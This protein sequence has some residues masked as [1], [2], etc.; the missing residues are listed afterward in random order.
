MAVHTHNAHW[1]PP[2]SAAS[3]SR[4]S[5]ARVVAWLAATVDVT[6]TPIAP[7]SCC[8]VLSRPE[9]SPA[10]RSATP[11]SPAIEIGMN[12]NAVPA[13]ATKNGPARSAPE[14]TVHGQPG[15]PT[16]IPARD[17]RH[18]GRHDRRGT[19]PRVTSHCVEPGERHRG[20]RRGQPRESGLQ[21]R[22]AEHLLHVERPDEDERIE[23]GAEQEADRVRAGDVSAAGSIRSGSS[24]AST[25]VSMRMNETSSA[26]DTASEPT[27]FTV[28]PPVVAAPVE[29]A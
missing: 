4:P 18:A 17:Q 6:A 11:A 13:P 15:S 24:G 7:P 5:V 16:A 14:P 22:I 9:A 2:V 27:V 26:P 29:M 25:R 8:D 10:S 21:R 23:A 19:D 3:G 28:A 1:N 20:Q 12:A